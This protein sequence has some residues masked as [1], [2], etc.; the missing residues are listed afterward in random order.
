[1]RS[2]AQVGKRKKINKET[3]QEFGVAVN[4]LRY[5]AG[6]VMKSNVSGRHSRSR[7]NLNVL[8]IGV[9]GESANKNSNVVYLVLVPAFKL[10]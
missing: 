4:V 5:T 1:M 3:Q 7:N 10:C 2:S 6:I 9:A 8:E